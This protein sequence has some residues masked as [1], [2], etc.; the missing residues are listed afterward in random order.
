MDISDLTSDPLT[1]R[2][3][4]ALMG[5]FIGDALALGPHWYYDLAE[6]H[7]DYGTW[8]TDYTTPKDGRYH[9]GLN[10]GDQSQAGYIL[11]MLLQSLAAEGGYSEKD[12][13]RRLDEDLFPQLDG[14]PMSGPGGYTSQSIRKAWQ[15]RVQQGKGWDET[16]NDADTTEAIERTLALAVRYALNPKK[17]AE[18]VVSNTVLTQNDGL[19][20]SM[21][22]AFN[23]VLGY[24]VEGNKLDTQISDALMTRVKDGELP[25]HVVTSD[26]YGPPDKDKAESTEAGTFASPDALLSPSYMATAAAD[27]D[28]QIEPAWKVSQVYGMPCAIYHQLPG[29]LLPG[30]AF[31]RRLRKR[32]AACGERRWSESGPRHSGGSTCRRASRL[33]GYSGA[34]PGRTE[35]QRQSA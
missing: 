26:N 17:L 18:S 13:C 16:G 34:F 20:V 2:C 15:I 33:I 11:K 24:L 30:R 19:V 27:P 9:E 25:F 31:C 1:D 21:T 14:K 12:F 6:Q 8:I 7:K 3:L 28:I 4:G 23:A 22:V 35:R 10:A 5:A 32:S 29:C